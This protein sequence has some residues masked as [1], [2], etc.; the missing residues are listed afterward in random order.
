M[1]GQL[2]KAI[3]DL[4]EEMR[5]LKEI[6]QFMIFSAAEVYEEESESDLSPVQLRSPFEGPN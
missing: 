3:D 5:E 4:R 2:Q 1:S 6:L